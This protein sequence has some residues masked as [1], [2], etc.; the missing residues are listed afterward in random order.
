MTQ[1]QITVSLVV[2]TSPHIQINEV[3]TRDESCPVDH[4]NFVDKHIDN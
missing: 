3:T 2:S 4:R 1:V